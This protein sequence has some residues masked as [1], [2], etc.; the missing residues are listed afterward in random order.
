MTVDLF[1]DGLAIL[2][3]AAMAIVAMTRD[4]SKRRSFGS[5]DNVKKN[6][7][8]ESGQSANY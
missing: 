8:G 7:K 2:T 6:R 4:N 3:L 5:Q 1:L